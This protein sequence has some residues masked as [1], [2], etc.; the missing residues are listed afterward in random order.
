METILKLGAEG[1][2]LTLLGERTNDEKWTFYRETQEHA[3]ADLINDE[4]SD[5]PALL[6]Q[7]S[8]LIESDIKEALKRLGRNWSNLYPV[9]VHSDFAWLIYKQVIEDS[10][11]VSNRNLHRWQRLCLEQNPLFE[12][13]QMLCTSNY[14]VVLSGAGMSTESGLPDFRSKDGWWRRIDPHLV[15]NIETLEDNYELFREF[16]TYRIE[17]VEQYSPHVGH[18]VLAKWEK[19]GLLHGIATQNVD[20]FHMAA[21]NRHVSELHGNLRSIRCNQCGREAEVSRF[22]SKESCMVCQGKLR[23]NIVLFGERLSEIAWAQA[24]EWFQAAELVIVIGTSLQVAPANQ[25]PQLTSGK[26]AYLNMENSKESNRF[27]ITIQGKAQKL[28]V[29]L[30]EMIQYIRTQERG[31]SKQVESQMYQKSEIIR[32]IGFQVNNINQIY[33]CRHLNYVGK[34]SDTKELFTEVISCELLRLQIKNRLNSIPEV[35]RERGYQI[36]SRYGLVTTNHSEKASN[37]REERFAIS[38]FNLSKNGKKF[39][40]IGKI[41]D[42]QVP[43]RNSIQDKGLG[44]I[45]LISMKDDQ[46]YLIELK[47]KENK[48]TILRCI[49]EIATYYQVLS[50]SKFLESYSHEFE[51]VTTKSIQKAILIVEGSKQ[52]QEMIKL[53]NGERKA[54]KKLLNELEVQVYCINP[55]SL[56]VQKL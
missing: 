44:K 55:E 8:K 6:N 53:Q 48:E 7:K 17:T 24:M 11:S 13:A 19:E 42:Y 9:E 29:Q 54:L 23:P 1:G 45:D 15:A 2:S 39:E 38:L 30:D 40:H 49:L 27:D 37:R 34:T 25:L 5:L 4:D 22:L 46:I 18:Q 35:V 51:H 28:L 32:G 16:Y 33:K 52:H 3:L 12:L 56:D 41:L 14:T 21:G 50:K 36:G 31:H 47:I 10:V 43:L 26:I 20:G